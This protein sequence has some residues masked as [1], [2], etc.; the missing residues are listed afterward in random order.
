[1]C[2]LFGYSA[3]RGQGLS[4]WLMPF[5]ERGGGKADNPDGWGVASWH[6]G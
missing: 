4:R 5:R 2:E 6:D 1:M 3:D